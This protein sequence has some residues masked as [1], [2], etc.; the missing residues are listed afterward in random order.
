MNLFR[1]RI[2]F[3]GLVVA[4]ISPLSLRAA[5]DA[6]AIADNFVYAMPYFTTDQDQYNRI[7]WSTANQPYRAHTVWNT[8]NEQYYT[9]TKDPRVPWASDPTQPVGDAAVLSLGTSSRCQW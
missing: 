6:N 9:D 7:F 4:A 3:A 8:V 2:L 1:P 5:S